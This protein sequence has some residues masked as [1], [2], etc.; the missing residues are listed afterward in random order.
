MHLRI[1]TV[2]RFFEVTTM[3]A[4][5]TILVCALML[6]T[7]VIAQNNDSGSSNDQN[8]PVL[9]TRPPEN[10]PNPPQANPPAQASNGQNQA[11]APPD[12]VPEGSRFIIK[13]KDTLDSRKMQQGDHFKAELREDLITP[14]GLMISKGRTIKGH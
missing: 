11:Y 3:K 12:V 5:W 1:P 6:C 2:L 14:G 8:H 7:A 10:N 4:A 13:L 9:T